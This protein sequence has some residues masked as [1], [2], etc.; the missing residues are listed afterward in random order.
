MNCKSSQWLASEITDKDPVINF[1]DV[2]VI[3]RAPVNQVVEQLLR[4][5]GQ[6]AFDYT[7]D[8]GYVR[9][10]TN[11]LEAVQ[12][13]KEDFFNSDFIEELTPNDHAFLDAVDKIQVE[14]TDFNDAL[15]EYGAQYSMLVDKFY[16]LKDDPL[17]LDWETSDDLVKITQEELEELIKRAA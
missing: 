17:G 8:A 3:V 16:G 10:E 11:P 7:S 13:E 6:I 12:E 9:V 2:V 15:Q 4:H 1:G 5:D 14:S